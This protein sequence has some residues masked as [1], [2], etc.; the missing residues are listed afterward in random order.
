MLVQEKTYESL[1]IRA[2]MGFNAVIKVCI[3]GSFGFV[4]P[5]G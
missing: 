4:A 5:D 3:G 2:K 1:E